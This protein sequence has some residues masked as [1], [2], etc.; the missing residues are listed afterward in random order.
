MVWT[1]T[2]DRVTVRQAC[3]LRQAR[4]LLRSQTNRP[5]YEHASAGEQAFISPRGCLL[6]RTC[7]MPCSRRER[8]TLT[9]LSKP[10]IRTGGF[11]PFE[12][13]QCH[14]FRPKLQA[15]ST[16]NTMAKRCRRS[17]GGRIL[18][19]S[20][21]SKP[22]AYFFE[23]LLSAI[24]GRTRRNLSARSTRAVSRCVVAAYPRRPSRASCV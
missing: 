21:S 14:D 2:L 15:E 23:Q 18:P 19:L 24:T 17:L 4:F 7:V 3:M 11:E 10:K 1:E 22:A 6:Q 12:G 13:T 20:T 5:T 8:A 9:L 16:P